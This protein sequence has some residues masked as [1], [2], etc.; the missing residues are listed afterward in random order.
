[1]ASSIANRQDTIAV[2]G[3]S[4]SV[5]TGT[6]AVIDNTW[7]VLSFVLSSEAEWPGYDADEA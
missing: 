5:A 3:E 7:S 6:K 2:E 1:M 4:L